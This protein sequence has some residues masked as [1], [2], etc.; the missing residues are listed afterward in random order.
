MKQM[1]EKRLGGG[2]ASVVRMGRWS[3]SAA[4]MLLV[5]AV[6]PAHQAR[7]DCLEVA[8]ELQQALTERNPVAARESYEAIERE[9]ECDDGFRDRAG[10]AVSELHTQIVEERLASGASFESQR[11]LLEHGLVYGR[12]WRAL[13]LLGDADHDARNYGRATTRYQEALMIIKDV[14][15]TETP[16]SQPVIKH[17]FDRAAQ[18]RM[19]ASRYLP[20]PRN[21]SGKLDGLAAS[22]TGI[23]GFTPVAVPIPITFPTDSAEFT[24]DGELYAEE[25]A[26]ILREQRPDRIV[27]SAHTD[28]RGLEAY[29][30]ELSRKRGEAVVQFLRERG[31]TQPIEVLAKGETEPYEI[32]DPSIY[33]R[34]ERWQMDRRVQLIR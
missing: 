13:A 18:S 29:N 28:E 23:R 10:L 31:F 2:S 30:L 32:P 9:V 17:L 25:L 3:V 27:L 12:T 4:L 11:A 34:E 14:V 15:A 21:R 16:P 24:S 22:G 19:L 8:Q 20:S 6:V 7:A 33:T 5:S 26:E 1:G